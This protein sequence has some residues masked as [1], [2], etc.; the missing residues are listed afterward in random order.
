MRPVVRILNDIWVSASRYI[1]V[2]VVG[3]AAVTATVDDGTPTSVPGTVQSLSLT[4]DGKLR[5]ATS[6]EPE[7]DF[8]GS[9]IP[10][11]VDSNPA[12]RSFDLWEI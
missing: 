4:T 11:M 6:P 12:E 10:N 3:A 9:D 1:R 7:L 8:F 2:Y 5:V